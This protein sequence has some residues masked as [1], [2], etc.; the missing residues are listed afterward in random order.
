MAGA[1]TQ[2]KFYGEVEKLKTEVKENLREKFLV[3]F[4]QHTESNESVLKVLLVM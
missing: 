4:Y 2:T 3:V 1:G